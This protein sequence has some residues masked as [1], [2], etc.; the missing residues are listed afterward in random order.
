MSSPPNDDA[1]LPTRAT[2]GAASGAAPVAAAGA[3]PVA[4]SRPSPGEPA[5][6][7]DAWAP[8]QRLARAGHAPG[9]GCGNALPM[10]TRLAEFELLR[11]LGEGGFGIVYLAQDHSLRRRVAI[12]EYM[13]A[14]LAHRA[15]GLQIQ[16]VAGRNRA[17]FNAGLVS[18]INEARLL[19]QFDHPSLVKVYRFWQDN[20]TAYM[21]MPFYEGA[22]L[23]LTLQHLPGQPDERWLMALLAALTEA[24]AVVHAGHCLHRDIAPDNILL[25][26]GSGRPLLLDFGAA[27]Q[28]IGDATQAL[29]AILKPGYAPVEQYAEAGSLRQGPWTDVYALC[30]VVHCAL[31]GKKPPVSVG[32]TVKDSYVPLTRSAAGRYSA[33]FLQA[34]D[35]G[36]KVQ[37][38]ERTPSVADLRRALGLDAP[39]RPQTAAVGAVLPLPT[40]TSTASSALAPTPARAPAPAFAPTPVPAAARAPAPAPA[41]LPAAP[42]AAGARRAAAP[43]AARARG[44]APAMPSRR[45][46]GWAALATGALLAAAS[47]GYWA[48]LRPPAP[49]AATPAATVAPAAAPAVAVAT[50]SGVP[51]AAVPAPPAPPAGVSISAEFDRIVQAG[52]AGFGVEAT[53]AQ[54]RLRIG[55]DRLAFKVTSARDGHVYVLLGGPDGSLLLLYPNSQAPQHQIRA[56][57]TLSLPQADWLLDTTEPAGAEHFLVLV[58]QH[59]RDFS[60]LSQQRETWFLKLPTGPAAQA[61]V[62]GHAGPGSALAGAVRCDQPGC[63]VYGVAR[64]SVDIV[65]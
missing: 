36:L 31:M 28:V 7:S 59:P 44:L 25:L 5:R 62:R 34:I 24:L 47:A 10:G 4:S 26:A 20:G 55:R 39:A 19:A 46:I 2:P 40:A 12:K 35:D 30:A 9:P 17:V 64:F 60:Q 18:F 22:T 57:Q 42:S 48:S 3:A 14:A 23:K 15:G 56:G 13:P 29:T 50:R 53:A 61:A 37:P 49:T 54:P 65:N 21:V 8:T 58:S 33:R 51:P 45:S 32:R 1:W 27:R 16:W 43:V 41:P 11:V 38:D 6:D 52:N 63:D